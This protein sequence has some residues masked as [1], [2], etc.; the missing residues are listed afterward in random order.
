MNKKN[1]F[2]ESFNYN[3]LVALTK[4]FFENKDNKIKNFTFF[5][6]DFILSPEQKIK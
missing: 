6:P 2:I 3:D 1:F 5:N 4:T